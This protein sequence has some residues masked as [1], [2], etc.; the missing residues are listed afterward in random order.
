MQQGCSQMKWMYTSWSNVKFMIGLF[1]TITTSFDVGFVSFNLD[2]LWKSKYLSSSRNRIIICLCFQP[3]T[4]T[5]II[6]D[7]AVSPWL[8]GDKVGVRVRAVPIFNWPVYNRSFTFS[9]IKK[10][11]SNLIPE[12]TSGYVLQQLVSKEELWPGGV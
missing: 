11:K 12:V 1:K 2:L 4:G 9:K 7:L 10:I 6:S 3:C 8:D 5:T